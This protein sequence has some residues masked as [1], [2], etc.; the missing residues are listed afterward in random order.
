MTGI[1]FKGNSYQTGT[2]VVYPDWYQKL[3]TTVPDMKLGYFGGWGNTPGW[4]LKNGPTKTQMVEAGTGN[5]VETTTSSTGRPAMEFDGKYIDTAVPATV[6]FSTIS[7]FDITAQ[8]ITDENVEWLFHVD[9]DATDVAVGKRG[10]QNDL[11][12]NIAS[13]QNVNGTATLTAGRYVVL[14]TAVDDGA[15]NVLTKLYINS[16]SSPN[17]SSTLS[18]A[19]VAGTPNYDIGGPAAAPWTS[20]VIFVGVYDRALDADPTEWAKVQTIL[21]EAITWTDT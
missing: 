8:Q 12:I 11:Y 1:L 6:T 2:S 16:F 18:R 10:S 20:P 5:S 17:A 7:I 3:Y 14:T 13:G 15:G 19:S 9:Y 21:G 4:R